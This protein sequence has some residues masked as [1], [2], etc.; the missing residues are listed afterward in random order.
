MVEE[1]LQLLFRG[2]AYFSVWLLNVLIYECIAIV[3]WLVVAY[4]AFKSNRISPKTSDRISSTLMGVFLIAMLVIAV[5]I[6][7]FDWIRIVPM[8]TFSALTS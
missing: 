8:P 1:A 2:L 5:L 6:C 3:I 7:C 4:W